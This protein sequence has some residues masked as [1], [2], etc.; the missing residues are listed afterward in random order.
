MRKVPIY[1]LLLAVGLAGAQPV[2]THVYN[3]QGD[4]TIWNAQGW[5]FNAIGNRPTTTWIHPLPDT[6]SVRIV[7]A[8]LTLETVGIDNCLE[9]AFLDFDDRREGLDK[10]TLCV[11]GMDDCRMGGDTIAVDLDASR[12]NG[13]VQARANIEFSRDKGLGDLLWDGDGIQLK[14]STLV[15]HTEP[16]SGPPPAVTPAP[17]TLALAATGALLILLAKR[18]TP[19]V[20]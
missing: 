15:V 3:F 9:T 10:V 16:L 19:R 8:T 14:R 7:S 12:L 4:G 6:D 1:L 5:V 11:D 2:F 17:G 13:S 20:I 18:K